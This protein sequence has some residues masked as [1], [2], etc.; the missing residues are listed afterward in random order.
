MAQ[1]FQNSLFSQLS[2]KPKCTHT[3]DGLRSFLLFYLFTFKIAF[4]LFYF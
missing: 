3:H 1:S 4:L 2:Q